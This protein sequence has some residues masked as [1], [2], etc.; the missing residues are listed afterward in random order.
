MDKKTICYNATISL[1]YTFI[2]IYNSYM[3]ILYI[4][5]YT[6]GETCI[7]ILGYSCMDIWILWI[8][9]GNQY[10]IHGH[11]TK[12]RYGHSGKESRGI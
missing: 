9:D 6:K 2:D 4:D 1:M 7:I 3:Y 10:R 11:F 5:T 12:L 8:Y